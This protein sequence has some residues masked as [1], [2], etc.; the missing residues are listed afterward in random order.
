M[1]L[2][3]KRDRESWS[4]EKNIESL[5]ANSFLE[6]GDIILV[7]ETGNF[8][9][10]VSEV[11]D[12]PLKKELYAKVIPSELIGNIETASKLKKPVNINLIGNV[13]GV[14]SFDGSEDVDINVKV[15]Q[16]E[17][18]RVIGLEGN[19]TGSATFD[20][21]KN[22]SIDVK[23]KQLETARTISLSG[24]VSGSAEF[25]GSD[26]TNIN[27]SVTGIDASKIKSGVLN[28][29]RI[30]NLDASKITS[31][32]IDIERLPSSALERLVEVENDVERFA[33]TKSQIQLG[34]VVKVKNTLKMYKVINDNKLNSE[35]GYSVFVAGRAAEVPWSGVTGKPGT[36]PPSTH[37]HT[38]EQI[39]NFPT[40]MKNPFGL[41]IKLNGT[42]Q[43]TYDGSIAKE[44]N[45]TPSG[46]GA[47][48]EGNY[49][50]S[51]HIHTAGQVGAYT[52][53]EVN[54]LLS[55]KANINHGNHVPAIQS[56]NNKVYLRNDNTW[57]TITPSDI[58]AQPAGKYASSDHTHNY[59]PLTGGTLSG[60]L[61]VTGNLNAGKVYN[62]VFNDYAEFF[63]RGEET[64][65]GDIISLDLNSDK[66][67]YVKASIENNFVVGVHSNSFAHLI[68]GEIP[69]EN[70]DFFNYNIK[71]FIPVG[72]AGRVKCKVQG[73]VKKGDCIVLGDI[74]GVGIVS[75]KIFYN[76]NII[77]YSLEEKVTDDIGLVKILIK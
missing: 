59:L 37:T 66:E 15:K 58:G 40:S 16:L 54:N 2:E 68:G 44:I 62:A 1:I 9:K 55:G 50:D 28:T 38:K 61:T 47:Q 10:V 39:T 41:T 63:E 32:I 25:D 53:V 52:K 74:K 67:I 77:G 34:D 24:E 73:K 26:N 21:T 60:S 72:L 23:V 17:T 20:G 5:K 6:L 35:D 45:I 30:P 4:R 8:Y 18:P 31:G 69:P 75:D 71:K 22:V 7:A 42:S 36:F 3:N 27:A 57:H 49:A 11:T 29:A 19:V 48:V 70:E 12:I 14:T 65:P 51:D 76:V 64:E 46:I 43:G 33:L 56:A 13:S